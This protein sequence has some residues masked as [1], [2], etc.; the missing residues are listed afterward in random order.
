MRRLI[1]IKRDGQESIFIEDK[2][3]TAIKKAALSIGE[4]ISEENIEL[5]KKIAREISNLNYEK[6]TVE[7]IQDLVEKKLMA[8]RKKNIA[9]QYILYREKRNQIRESKSDLMREIT[10]KITAS[11]V[12][13]QNANVDEK[14]FGGR[15]GAVNNA[16]LKKYALDNCVNEKSRNNH[17]NNEIYIHDLDSYASG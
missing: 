13:N 8:S 12:E 1:V 14:S 10:V 4:E 5:A 3:V 9:K 6:I 15:M 7:D 16:V 11:N 2:I 17:L